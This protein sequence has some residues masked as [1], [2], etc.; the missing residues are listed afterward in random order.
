MSFN[1]L[2]TTIFLLSL[3]LGLNEHRNPQI[4]IRQATIRTAYLIQ[5]IDPV[6][7][8]EDTMQNGALPT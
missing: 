4:V 6:I 7:G 3:L 8:K 2:A 5:P 1:L